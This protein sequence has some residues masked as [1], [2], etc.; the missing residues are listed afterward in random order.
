MSQTTELHLRVF[1]ALRTVS[2]EKGFLRVPIDPAFGAKIQSGEGSVTEL[3]ESVRAYLKSHH[4]D[5]D[6]AMVEE[7]AIADESTVLGPHARIDRLQGWAV[8]PPVCGG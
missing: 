8:L 4:P 7:C 2:D 1:G 5:F 3:K 6:S